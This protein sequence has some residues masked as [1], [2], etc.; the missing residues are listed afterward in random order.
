MMDDDKCG[1]VS[2]I[3]DKENRNTRR[4]ASNAASS[5]TNPK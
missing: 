3:I 1:E 4:K 5:T 2:G